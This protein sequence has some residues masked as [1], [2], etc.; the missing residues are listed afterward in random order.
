MRIYSGR[1]TPREECLHP[2]FLLPKGAYPSTIAGPFDLCRPAEGRWDVQC[3]CLASYRCITCLVLAGGHYKSGS[4]APPP[5]GTRRAR[6]RSPKHGT[7]AG[8][9]A[10]QTDGDSCCLSARRGPRA[11]ARAARA[12]REKWGS[13]VRGAQ[14]VGAP[15]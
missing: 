15:G 12:G 1:K 9:G 8:E 6:A 10:R 7:A 3:A 14:P 5:V 11:L 13:G 2:V 4:H